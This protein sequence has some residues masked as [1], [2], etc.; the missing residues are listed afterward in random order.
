[1][2]SGS[3]SFYLNTTKLKVEISRAKQETTRETRTNGCACRISEASSCMKSKKY[4]C[5]LSYGKSW[6]KKV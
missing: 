5:M 2:T 3:K 1:M 4:T 6:K